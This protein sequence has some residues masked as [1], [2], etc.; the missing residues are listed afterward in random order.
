MIAYEEKSIEIRDTRSKDGKA[1]VTA[2]VASC[3]LAYHP[4]LGCKVTKIT[5]Q[6][7]TRKM[8]EYASDY[9][10][11]HVASGNAVCQSAQHFSNQTQCHVFIE[12]IANLTDWTAEQ[13]VLTDEIKMA[14]TAK[15]RQWRDAL[16]FA[17]VEF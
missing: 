11:T 14:I 5:W 8:T 4:T 12:Q 3:G 6:D 16:L 1:I 7:T 13:P 17:E 15:A 10:V 9:T 2:H